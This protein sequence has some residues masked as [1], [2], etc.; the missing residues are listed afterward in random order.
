MRYFIVDDDS[1]SRRMLEQIVKEDEL[2]YM[3]GEAENGLLAIEPIQAT[4]PDV[5]LIDLLMPALRW[6]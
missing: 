2:G 4:Q 5:V 6:Y 1:A 3:V